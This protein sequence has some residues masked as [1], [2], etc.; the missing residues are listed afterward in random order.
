[1]PSRTAPRAADPASDVVRWGAF[2]SAL[3]PV[4]LLACGSSPEGA[5]GTAA[6]LAAVTA[7]CRALLRRAARGGRPPGARR[8]GPHR[9]RHSRTGSGAHRGGRRTSQL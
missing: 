4:V 8:V 3:V 5:L 9:G 6:G 7:A 1:M 2:S